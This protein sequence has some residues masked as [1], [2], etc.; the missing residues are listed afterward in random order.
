[1]KLGVDEPKCEISGNDDAIPSEDQHWTVLN[2]R[3][4]A[5]KQAVFKLPKR[6][7]KWEN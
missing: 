3:P 7:P 1:L 2:N 6:D 5:G 4:H